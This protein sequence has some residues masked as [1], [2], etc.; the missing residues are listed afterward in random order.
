MNTQSELASGS[1]TLD[2]TAFLEAA[3]TNPWIKKNIWN[4]QVWQLAHGFAHLDARTINDFSEEEL[5][6]LAISH[7]EKFDHVGFIETFEADGRE[8]FSALGF[9]QSLNMPTVNSTNGR[10][11]LKDVSSSEKKCLRKLRFWIGNS[12]TMHGLTG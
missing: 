9:P 8:I 10:P 1:E 12:I 11:L 6:E 5:L 4:N 3:F 2:L 7:L